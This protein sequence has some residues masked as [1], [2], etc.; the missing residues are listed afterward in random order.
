[1]T[2]KCSHSEHRPFPV[3]M[4]W[5]TEKTNRRGRRKRSRR[6][7]K[8][9]RD[10]SVMMIQLSL[11]LRWTHLTISSFLSTSLLPNLTH[12]HT[13][14]HTPRCSSNNIG[15]LTM[16]APNKFRH[17]KLRFYAWAIHAT[18]LRPHSPSPRLQQ[19]SKA[20]S[21]SRSGIVLHKTHPRTLAQ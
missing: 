14:A 21:S 16:L 17:T 11:A 1:M 18:T 12:A 8:S 5:H 19:G 3:Q 4:Q 10:K 9:K 13:R 20:Q 6:K 15:C 2:N 7:R